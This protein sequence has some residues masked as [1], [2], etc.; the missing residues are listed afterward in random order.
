[1][2][3]SADLSQLLQQGISAFANRDFLGADDYFCQISDIS[4]DNWTARY[5]HAMTLSSIGDF[6]E[7]RLQLLHI[8]L[9]STEPNWQHVAKNGI[10]LIN[11][12]EQNL[13]K[14]L[15]HLLEH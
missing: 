12:K 5:F 15:K 9:R 11:N 10:S 4:P 3:L 1:M 2:S 7:A 13:R 8:E 14:S 6:S